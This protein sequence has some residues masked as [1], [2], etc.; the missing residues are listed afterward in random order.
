MYY[1]SSKNSEVAA[2]KFC[3][4]KIYLTLDLKIIGVFSVLK[5]IK[6][7]QIF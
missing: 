2:I 7:Y 3:I 4:K 1:N 5:Q 6:N